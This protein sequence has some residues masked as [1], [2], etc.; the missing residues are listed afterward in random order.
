[1]EYEQFYFEMRGPE[2][3][4]SRFIDLMR[5]AA[6][7]PFTNA[8]ASVDITRMAEQVAPRESNLAQLSPEPAGRQRSVIVR[9][10]CE[11]QPFLER[12][13]QILSFEMFG[14]EVPIGEVR[15]LSKQFGRCRFELIF[16]VPDRSDGSVHLVLAHGQVENWSISTHENVIIA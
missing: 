6:L 5:A 16:D 4:V 1:M 12:W 7:E 11:P 3:D 8:G 14:T 2:A 9:T 13:F 15:R 10:M